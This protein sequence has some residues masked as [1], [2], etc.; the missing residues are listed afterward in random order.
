MNKFVSVCLFLFISA[1]SFA[2]SN[3]DFWYVS[4]TG[5]GTL[6]TSD[7]PVT[8]AY[9]LANVTPARN[10]IRVLGGTYSFSD[11]ILLVSDVT[12]EGGYQISGSDWVLSSNVNTNFNVIPPLETVN[13]GGTD[14]GHYVGV[15]ASGLTG[16]VLRNLT[17]NVKL[18]GAT[19]T[20]DNRGR[21][22]YGLYLDGSSDYTIS[23]VVVNTGDASDGA[24][25]VAGQNGLSGAN[26]D[27]GQQGNCDGCFFPWCNA[28]AGAPGGAGGLGGGGTA[29]GQDGTG[30][31]GGG[32]GKGGNGGVEGSN[33]G[34]AGQEGGGVASSPA[35]TTGGGTAGG[36]GDPGGDGANGSAGANGTAGANGASSPAGTVS[37]GFFIPGAQASAGVNGIAG[38]GGRGGGG[39][40]GQGCSLCDDGPGNAGGAGG[41]G[42]QAGTGGTGGY[43]GGSTYG[44]FAWSNGSNGNIIDT[45]LNPGAAG[46]GGAGGLGGSG[47]AGGNG[48]NGATACS[49]EIGEGGDGG[50]GGSGGSGGNGASGA[51]GVALASASTGTALNVLG[52]T[53]PST[54]S[55]VTVFQNQGCTNSEITI[56]KNGGSFD[57]TGMGNAQLVNDLDLNTSSFTIASNNVAVYYG[58]TGQQNVVISGT[59][60]NDY[61][62]IVTSR[63]LPVI[64]VLMNSLPVSSLCVGASVDL[65]TPTV[66]ASYE[67][68]IVSSAI[69]AVPT[70]GA[71]STSSSHTFNSVGTF[72]VKLRVKDECCGWSIPVYQ[73]ITV[74]PGP[75]VDLGIE[76]TTI[77]GQNT[78]TFDA[79][80]G[81]NSYSWSPSGD[82]T[83]TLTIDNTG[84]YTVFV[85]DANGCVGQDQVQVGVS[86]P[87]NLVVIP[88]GP[89]SFCVGGEVT[90]S[91]DAGFATYLWSDGSTTADSLT[92]T[93]SG[94]YYVIVEDD[95]GC[96]GI[97][98]IVQVSVNSL[99]NAAI[100]AL[101]PLSFCPGDS[102]ILAAPVGYVGYEWSSGSSNDSIAVN[103][104]Q[105]VTLTVTSAQGCVN[106]SSVDVS[107]YPQPSPQIS[108]DGPFEFCTGENVVLSVG[109]NYSSYLWSS[110]STSQTITVTESGLYGV[111]VIDLNGCVDSTLL[112][113]PVSVTVFEP[114]PV[115]VQ[116][117]DSL[118]ITNAGDFG[119][120]QWYYNGNPI[121]GEN[122]S[123]YVI[124]SSGNYTAS[125]T[126]DNGCMGF[127]PNYEMTCCVGIGEINDLSYLNIY[128]NPTSGMI[129]LEAEFV[130]ETE[131][132]ILI[133]DIA[134]KEMIAYFF[135][136][137]VSSVQKSFDLNTLASGVYFLR[138]TTNNGAIVHRIVKK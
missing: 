51:S 114:Q 68:S 31:N 61:I 111:S 9:A 48:G 29:A 82:T 7:Q 42:G 87:L 47:A 125:G 40:G 65:N 75:T 116:S 44:V 57:L 58:T 76:D 69:G 94:D 45:E 105:Q 20:T 77:C 70:G 14:V 33:A 62:D 109:S 64:E 79:G 102:V 11:K 122:G 99:P 120:I 36:G 118:I 115:I 92:V 108:G 55:P 73:E 3:C 24:G 131:V 6:G 12:I 113:T 13:I 21:N 110:G 100:N 59:V 133:F 43:G 129:T 4:P 106:S 34:Q 60:Y 22:I 88:D 27:L 112:A 138:V 15:E 93:Q 25:G 50:A 121:S 84:I 124:T 132:S 126:D 1:S 2:Q 123:V 49:S 91:S 18:A 56:S 135:G 81:F 119:A 38:K 95:L 32:G 37:G 90:L 8:F 54:Y 67:W 66:G 117:G 46:A 107:I 86:E 52:T 134:G 16:F 128:P 63:P 17:I 71:S 98:Q 41:G 28:G 30:V 85:T 19:G 89:T 53:V 35:N 74:T 96:T 5:A 101:G 136:T 23:R 39:G 127:S 104:A 72:Y 103:S 83:Q 10:H 80:I 97:S 78:I 137:P 130:N 26:G